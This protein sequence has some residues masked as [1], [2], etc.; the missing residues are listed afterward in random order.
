MTA[1]LKR[2]PRAGIL[3][4]WLRRPVYRARVARLNWR[5]R[6]VLKELARG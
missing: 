5:L 1:F 3:V 4:D 2:H 6:R